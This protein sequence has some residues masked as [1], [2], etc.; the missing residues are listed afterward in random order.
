V[1]IKK[2]QKIRI[3]FVWKRQPAV[4][5]I[6]VIGAVVFW[7]VCVTQWAIKVALV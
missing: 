3:I 5:I 4:K 2:K 7:R 6:E 1:S